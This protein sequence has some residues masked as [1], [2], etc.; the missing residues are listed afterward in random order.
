MKALIYADK[1][2]TEFTNKPEPDIICD[3]DAIVQVTMSAICT[4][5]L[6]IINN[7]V[8]RAKKGVTLGHEFTGV[9]VKTGDKVK[10]LKTGDRISAN[11]ITFCNKCYYCKRGFINNCEN[12][13]WELGCTIDGAQAEFVRVPYADN[14]LAKLPDNVSYKNALFVGDILSSGYFGALMCEINKDDT[15]AVI[16]SGPVGMCAMMCAKYMGA[17]KVIAIDIDNARLKTAIEQNLC[18]YAINPHEQDAQEAVKSLTHGRGADGVIEAAGCDETFKLAWQIARA[19]AIVGIVAMYEKAQILPLCDMYG[20][21]LTFK[22][23]GVDAIHCEKLVELISKGE[24]STDFLITH[25]VPFERIKEG[26]EIFKNKK[27]NCLKVAVT[28]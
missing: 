17:K 3:S 19:N 15:I 10:N 18:D 21:N 20:K 28:Y 7:S 12:G 2:K 27:D 23:G 22:T 24:I 25:S 8:P 6:H 26:Y 5:D 4:S 13:G 11:C 14:T 16:G 9:V 1:N